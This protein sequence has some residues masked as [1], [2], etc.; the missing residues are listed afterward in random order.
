M[1]I[2]WQIRFQD[3]LGRC[4]SSHIIQEANGIHFGRTFAEPVRDWMRATAQIFALDTES[5]TL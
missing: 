5:G 3:K 1:H 2:P 4:Q